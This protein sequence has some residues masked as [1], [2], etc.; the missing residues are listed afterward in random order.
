MVQRVLIETVLLLTEDELEKRN[1]GQS[2]GGSKCK[3]TGKESPLVD[4][5]E[6]MRDT[7]LIP[8]PHFVVLQPYS[9]VPGRIN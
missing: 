6:R 2:V 9:K 7:V 8:F 1:L 3:P 4:T 5:T